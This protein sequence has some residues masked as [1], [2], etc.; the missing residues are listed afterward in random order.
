MFPA[1]LRPRF[2]RVCVENTE[3]ELHP[4]ESSSPQCDVVPAC[5]ENPGS[6]GLSVS[7]DFLIMIRRSSRTCTFLKETGLY[8]SHYETCLL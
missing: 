7:P 3:G 4:R 1:L 5:P 8:E 2:S 6:Q